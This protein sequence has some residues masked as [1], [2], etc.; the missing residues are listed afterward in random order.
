MRKHGGRVVMP[1]PH[2]LYSLMKGVAGLVMVRLPLVAAMRHADDR[3][4]RHEPM[5][6]PCPNP[7][8]SLQ[9]GKLSMIAPPRP[10]GHNKE[11]IPARRR[12]LIMTSILAH[13]GRILEASFVRSGVRRPRRKPP[14]RGR[15][16]V[17]EDDGP[18]VPGG[19]REYARRHYDRLWD[20]THLKGGRR[21]RN[22][23]N[24]ARRRRDRQRCPAVPE[25]ESGAPK[26]AAAGVSTSAPQSLNSDRRS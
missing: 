2:R 20:M 18:N 8:R 17:G 6:P 23:G 12:T 24:R 16:Q 5:P 11:V 1:S 7:P 9:E 21:R 26:I 15:P 22:S 25:R 19:L 4:G 13:R 3:P 10:T 14:A